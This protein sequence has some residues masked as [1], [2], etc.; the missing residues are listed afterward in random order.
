MQGGRRRDGGSLSRDTEGGVRVKRMIMAVGGDVSMH[1]IR[2]E[3]VPDQVPYPV[4]PT[5]DTV[6]TRGL[7]AHRRT[8][9]P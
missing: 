9:P 5:P 4:R 8:R 3:S 1:K 2:P 7:F 6:H